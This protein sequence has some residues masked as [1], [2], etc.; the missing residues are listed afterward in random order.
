MGTRRYDLPT[1]LWDEALTIAMGM[2][3]VPNIGELAMAKRAIVMQSALFWERV[4]RALVT[5]AAEGRL[6]EL[7]DGDRQTMVEAIASTSETGNTPRTTPDLTMISQRW[8]RDLKELLAA[9]AAER[10]ESLT[11]FTLRAC[12]AQMRRDLD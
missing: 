10:N 12:E 5:A 6:D 7:S 4:R 1:S 2:P 8:P 11:E 3:G 9:H